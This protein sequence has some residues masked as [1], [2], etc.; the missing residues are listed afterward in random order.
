MSDPDGVA[1]IEAVVR[2]LLRVLL[3]EQWKRG[4]T[5]FVE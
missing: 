5:R 3:W 1:G 2:W 4:P